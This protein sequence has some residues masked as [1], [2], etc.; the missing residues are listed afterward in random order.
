MITAHSTFRNYSHYYRRELVTSKVHGVRGMY[1]PEP[2]EPFDDDY[3]HHPKPSALRRH[4]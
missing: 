2:S 3:A 4:V 1:P